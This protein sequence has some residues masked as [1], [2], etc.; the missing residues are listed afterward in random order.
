[1]YS[2]SRKFI[3]ARLKNGKIVYVQ[4]KDNS[5]ATFGRNL[6]KVFPVDKLLGLKINGKYQLSLQYSVLST[7]KT[8]EVKIFN[9][10]S[11][12]LAQPSIKKVMTL[13]ITMLTS[14]KFYLHVSST[15]LVI[16]FWEF[17]MFYQIFLSPQVKRIVII[18]NKHGIHELPHE[19]QNDLR[20]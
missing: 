8:W 5:T 6:S 4:W 1:M 3:H 14:F 2:Y 11:I 12:L 7:K 13:D 17:L 15:I 16:I 19:F 10:L 9:A 18:S 20:Y